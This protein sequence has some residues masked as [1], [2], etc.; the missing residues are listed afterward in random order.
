[1]GLSIGGIAS[2][3]DTD[4]II[5]QLQALQK[6]PILQLQQKEADYQVK[7]SAYST[8]R[9]SLATLQSAAK[10]LSSLSNI[11]S[12]SATSSN[13][14]LLTASAESTATSGSYSITVNNLAAA[15][16]L[17]SDTNSDPLIDG[18]FGSAEFIGKGTI[19]LALGS[20]D[21]VDIDVGG[22]STISDVAKAINAAD[23][24][25]Y[26]S[27][28]SDGTSSFL[29][30][31]GKQTGE[32]N[33][34]SLTVTEDGTDNKDMFGLSRLYSGNLK[35]TQPAANSDITVD[36]VKNIDRETNTIDDVIS[37]VTLNLKS[38]GS[39]ATVSVERSDDLFTTQMNAF[40]DAYNGLIDSLNKLQSYDSGTNTAGTLLGDATT[41]QIH[42]QVRSLI[43]NSVSGL[44]AGVNR[45]TDFGVS[46][47]EDGKLSLDSTVFKAKL[48]DNFENVSTFFTKTDVGFAA[49]MVDSMD[50]MLDTY[51]GV[52]AVRTKGIQKS[53]DTIDDRITTLN[54]RMSSSETRLRAQFS[55]LEVTLAKYQGLSSSLTA[56]LAQIQNGWGTNS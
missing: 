20:A 24:G 56:S 42:S 6:K 43:S 41:R 50:T 17:T 7:I 9:T 23:A 8:L 16:K 48:E 2:G 1:M 53:I 13:T 14:S 34:I 22:T 54:D 44:S 47:D 19:H 40:L 12:Y 46:T 49:R 27:V 30:L 3:M 18:G 32:D 39:T 29:T 52:L 33:V 26:A 35:V 37:G 5:S 36:G 51:D 10:K 45:L 15:Q 25:V 31:T 21:A 28:V 38:A 4:S 55:A 11:T